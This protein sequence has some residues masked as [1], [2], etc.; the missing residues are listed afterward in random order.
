MDEEINISKLK[1][2]LLNYYGTAMFNASPLAI[3]GLAKIEKASEDEL[4]QIAIDNNFDLNEYKY[5]QY[6]NK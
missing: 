4:V 2:D 6:R 5:Y 3:I 1:E